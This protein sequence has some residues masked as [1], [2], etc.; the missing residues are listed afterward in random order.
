MPNSTPEQ[1]RLY[2]I[3]IRKHGDSSELDPDSDPY[4][5]LLF[6]NLLPALET[7]TADFANHDHPSDFKI[8]ISEH[9]PELDAEAQQLL[10][11]NGYLLLS[12]DAF[13]ANP[14]F[15][16]A[17]YS[18]TYSEM[19]GLTAEELYHTFLTTRI[20]FGDHAHQDL[21]DSFSQPNETGFEVNLLEISMPELQELV[22]K[23]Q[24]YAKEI[25]TQQ[26]RKFHHLSILY[27]FRAI[28][29]RI[30]ISNTPKTNLEALKI[31][32]PTTFIDILYND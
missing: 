23:Y 22:R 10:L 6:S 9:L 24:P 19:T 27:F 3:E 20:V 17:N 4:L 18:A 31:G 7:A 12:P 15:G 11:E 14:C 16:T 26:E 30:F 21:I 8:T 1:T 25:G 2:S 29:E 28:H 32:V 13:R 5:I